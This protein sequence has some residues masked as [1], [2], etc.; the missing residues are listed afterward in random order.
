MS[1]RIFEISVKG[2]MGPRLRDAF[3]DV[4]PTIDH[5][6]TR[7]RVAGSDTST[8]HGILDRLESF[9]LELLELH[10]IGS[11]SPGSG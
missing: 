5:G 10:S 8:L 7:L 4:E 2:E 1:Q 3:E 9:G 11:G 6:I